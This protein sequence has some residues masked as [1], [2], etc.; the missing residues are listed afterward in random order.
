M[1][2]I[3]LFSKYALVV[4]FKDEKGII[5]VNA[6][7]SILNKSKRKP[8]KIWV[9]KGSEFYNTSFKKWLQDNDIIMYSTNN[10]GKSVVAERFTRTLKSKIYKHMTSISKNVY[11]DKLNVIVNKYNTYHTT[12]KVN[13][14]DVKDNT[15]INTDKEINY[16]D[17]K[18]K[19]GDY[20]RISKYKNIFAKGYMPN[21]SEEV[22]VINKIKNTVP[23]TYV[24]N[25]LNGEEITGTFYENELQKT[26]QKEFRI[27]KVI[28]RKGDK[29]YVKWKGYD[30]SFNSWINKNDIIK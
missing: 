2:V 4:P 30:N 3:D 23:W 25:D 10:E 19:V 20:V 8:N 6:F 7:Q 27:E 15:Y 1:C 26:N 28:K 5:I 22:F 18:F 24:I 21:W 12:I 13:P 14:I 11:I 29:L 17:P 16:K 9:D